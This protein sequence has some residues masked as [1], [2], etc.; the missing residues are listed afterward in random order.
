MDFIVSQIGRVYQLGG[1]V[2]IILGL[3]SIAA[4]GVAIFK[5][6]QFRALRVGRN[7]RLRGAVD[8]WDGG[9]RA[10]ALA[11]AAMSRSH[12]APVLR[13]GMQSVEAGQ[14][15]EE[16]SARLY[17]EAASRLTRLE[18]GF[19]FLDVVAQLAPLLGLF[20]TVLGMIQ[21]FQAMQGA[22]RNVDPSILAEGIWVAL[23]T[24]AVGLAV[25]MP[26]TALLSWLESIV[27]RE[28]AL[29]DRALQ[30][31]LRPGLPLDGPARPASAPDHRPVQARTA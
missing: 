4:V 29:A 19:R 5:L 6:W 30:A 10:G 14:D 23:L 13:A 3:M 27:A 28:R 17:A 31:V 25:A 2:T 7:V 22:G 12:L 26:V 16:V 24:T 1:S 21:S 20:G 9:D 15:P 18:G 11:E 8:R